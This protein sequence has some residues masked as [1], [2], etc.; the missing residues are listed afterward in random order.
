MVFNAP[1]WL[2]DLGIAAWFLVGVGLLLV[3]LVWLFA[4]TSEITMPVTAAFIVASVASPIVTWL[5]APPHPARA[6][7]GHRPARP[8]RDRHL[9][10]GPRPRRDHLADGGDRRH[11]EPGGRQDPELAHGRRR[12][13]LGR[14]VGEQPDAAGRAGHPRDAPDRG[15]RR[16]QG[17]HEPRVRPV[18]RAPQPLL[19]AQGRPVHARVG[20]PPRRPPA[21][22]R[23]HDHAQRRGLAAPLLRRGHD[24]RGLQRAS[25]SA[26]ARSCSASPWQARSPSCRS[27]P[28]YV[29]YIGAFVAGAFAVIIA[30]G[31]TDTADG[32]A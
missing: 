14:F 25:S 28:A 26:S 22:G 32:A 29:P 2:R 18:V 16:H 24:R 21:P 11:C 1:R 12:R 15:R 7:R 19:P 3:S 8:A 27:S 6:G 5:K 9:R 31:S 20:Q 4:V 13:L 30:L 23:G 10:A 17:A